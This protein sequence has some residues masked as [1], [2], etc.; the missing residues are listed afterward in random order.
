MARLVRW[1]PLRDLMSS[2]EAMDRVF[3]ESFVRPREG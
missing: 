1:V 2:R 3:E